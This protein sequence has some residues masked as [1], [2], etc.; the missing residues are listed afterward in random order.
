MS[1]LNSPAQ[2]QAFLREVADGSAEDW[3]QRSRQTSGGRVTSPGPRRRQFVTEILE[4]HRSQRPEIQDRLEICLLDCMTDVVQ[5]RAVYHEVHPRRLR[6]Q[7][8][9]WLRLNRLNLPRDGMAFSRVLLAQIDDVAEQLPWS[10]VHLLM[11]VLR[12]AQFQ[13]SLRGLAGSELE[14]EN[15]TNQLAQQ[16][17]TGGDAF[18]ITMHPA[19]GQVSERRVSDYLMGIAGRVRSQ[20]GRDRGK[21][22]PLP[23]YVALCVHCGFR[24]ERRDKSFPTQCA[25]CCQPIVWQPANGEVHNLDT[26]ELGRDPPISDQPDVVDLVHDRFQM[27][28]IHK[29]LAQLKSPFDVELF[30]RWHGLSP[31]ATSP[32]GSLEIANAF[33]NRLGLEAHLRSRFPKWKGYGLDASVK[34]DTRVGRVN[35]WYEAVENEFHRLL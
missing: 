2:F 29:A 24:N 14:L 4:E 13:R 33:A 12:S 30:N 23:W 22:A 15:L 5:N 9:I 26:E 35:A 32:Q 19:T 27:Q 1:R 3:K 31:D 18:M 11:R 10:P 21:R 7:L 20:F 6:E 17:L 8:E 28:R 25:T 34:N 16:I